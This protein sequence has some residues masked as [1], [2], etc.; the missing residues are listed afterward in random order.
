MGGQ[1][2]GSYGWYWTLER[3]TCAEP[4]DRA[5]HFGEEKPS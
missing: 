5:D 3:I 2:T 1:G 4:G